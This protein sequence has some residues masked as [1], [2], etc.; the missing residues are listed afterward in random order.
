MK[1]RYLLPL[2]LSFICT[3]SYGQVI[4]NEISYNPPEA[5]VDSLEYIELFNSGNVM[6]NIGGW[7][8]ETG[9]EDTLPNVDLQPGEYFVT[10]VSS[11]A[12]FNVFGINAHQ[13]SGNALSN[14]GESIRLVDAGGNL[15]DSVFY[16][17]S[18]PW[19]TEPDGNGPSLELIDAGL[20]NNDGIN[21]QFS[22]GTTGV[23]INGAE[24]S[25]TP[26]EENSGGGTAGPAVI[27][28]LANFKFVPENVVVKIGDVVR[29]VNS[30][31]T[32]HNVDG[33]QDVFPLNPAPFAS[34]FPTPGP[35]QFDF[36]FTVPGLYHYQCDLH[37]ITG[38][39][40][41]VSV[42]DPDSYTDFPLQHL[43]LTDTNGSHIFDGVPTTVTGVVHGTNFQPTG[44]SFYVIDEVNVGINVFSFDPGSYVVTEGDHVKVSGVIDQFNGLLEIIPDL[45]E[46]LSSGNPI[47]NPR[48][49]TEITEAD[50]SSYLFA[51]L[52]GV[53]SVANISAAGYNIYTTHES[54][55]KVLIRVDADANLQ[56][57][58]DIIV[59]SWMYVW[60]FGTQFD[61]SFPFTSGYQILALHLA[62]FVDGIRFL[63]SSEIQ[64]APNPSMDVVDLT[65]ELNMTSI[66][67]Y[68]LTGS[69]FLKE[70][71]I[72]QRAQINVS[73][74]PPGLYLIKALT[75]GG[76]WTSTLSVIR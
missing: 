11:Q 63:A 74:L 66:E 31:G 40:G 44:Y 71:V 61:P 45:I 65:S 56:S 57:S 37:G 64:M 60:G 18:D 69:C 67:L 39:V 73:N 25:G 33:L 1:S 19:P 16:D 75:D 21:W 13:W 2:F 34:G 53:D 36:T 59:G 49:I 41:T 62:K 14:N 43:R 3:I 4:I 26:G 17:D 27:I 7:Y 6:V 10:A 48:N 76:V 55:S 58:D 46:V 47:N 22:G 24:V 50:E 51:E 42:Y 12:M 30:S 29:W 68:S 70:N 52:L 20:D 8:F 54:G 38:M 9:V 32:S 72:G 5:N 15:I 28:D 23:I 35:W